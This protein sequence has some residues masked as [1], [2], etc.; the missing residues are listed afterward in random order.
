MSGLAGPRQDSIASSNKRNRNGQDCQISLTKEEKGTETKKE[1]ENQREENNDRVVIGA[2]P[3]KGSSST[4]T[5][6]R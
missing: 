5:A 1:K 6:K 4:K 3:P 2:V